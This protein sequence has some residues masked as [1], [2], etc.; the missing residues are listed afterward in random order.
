MTLVILLLLIF[1]VNLCSENYLTSDQLH[2]GRMWSKIKRLER[3]DL[4]CE[5]I[6]ERRKEIASIKEHWRP[7]IETFKS[8]QD[9]SFY[10][11]IEDTLKEGNLV[12][13]PDGYGAAYFLLNQAGEPCFVVKPIDEDILC[14]NNH[15]L[16]ASPFNDNGFRVR[17]YIPL[18]RSAQAETVSYVAARE[19]GLSHLTPKTVIS[20]ISNENFYDLSD[21]LE[22]AER[23]E[24]IKNAGGPDKEKLCSIQEY[25]P[26]MS[27]LYALCQK[28]AA[29]QITAAIHQDDFE[30]M[31]I[32]IW[33][34]YDTD[35]HGGNIYVRLDS[36]SI[37]RLKKLDNGLTFP[38]K[39]SYLRNDLSSLEDSNKVF[40][41]RARLI[42]K[43]I[44]INKIAETLDSY[45]M[46]DSIDPFLKRI[47]ILQE[48]NQRAPIS[49]NEMNLRLRALEL[50]NG[51]E[52]AL[53]DLPREQLERRLLGE[54]NIFQPS[55]AD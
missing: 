23:E 16:F 22:G 42:I 6:L 45:E 51:R 15:K 30:D 17:T 54:F 44:Y 36:D 29:G 40:T 43:N 53:I 39:N 7:K 38:E 34:F 9:A 3:K 52:I 20:I 8:G 21:S 31:M 49:I 37:Y 48:L 33:L 1:S 4:L 55:T 32:L 11:K 27:A 2:F 19:M 13:S 24:F 41:D 5:I 46:Q 14:L 28:W 35:A 10:Q 50:P 47:E 25:I 12:V 18:Y 26:D